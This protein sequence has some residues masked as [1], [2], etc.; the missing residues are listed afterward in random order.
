[1]S[2]TTGLRITSRDRG[3]L[4]GYTEVECLEHGFTY[5]PPDKICPLC[6]TKAKPMRRRP[7]VHLDGNHQ[8]V[9]DALRDIGAMVRS[10]AVVGDGFPDLVVGFRGK[11]FLLEVKNLDGRGDELTKLEAIFAQAWSLHGGPFMVVTSAAQAVAFV[12]QA[13]ER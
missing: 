2:I 3:A 8:A 7:T 4:A 13:D 5:T 6:P 1:M 12:F 10:T 9:V 11:T